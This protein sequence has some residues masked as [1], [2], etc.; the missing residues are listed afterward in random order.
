MPSEALAKLGQHPPP[1][2]LPP[3]RRLRRTRWWA[4]RARGD[5]Q[6]VIV[7][8]PD[9]AVKES[10]DRVNTAILNSRLRSGATPRHTGFEMPKERLTINLAPAD[11]KKEGPIFDLPIALG[12]LATMGDIPMAALGIYITPKYR[13]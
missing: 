9:A 12:V 10:K 5:P 3:T 8:L 7:G 11:I 2:R 1:P 6:T 4:G 13:N